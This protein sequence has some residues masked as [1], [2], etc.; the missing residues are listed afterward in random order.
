MYGS[1]HHTTFFDP[2]IFGAHFFFVRGHKKLFMDK[3]GMHEEDFKNILLLIQLEIWNPESS[4]LPFFPVVTW[5]M[6]WAIP[7]TP[8]F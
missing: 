8:Q 1:I 2:Y 5:A 4:G 6:D 3:H 7:A